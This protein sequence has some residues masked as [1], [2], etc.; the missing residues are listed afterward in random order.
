MMDPVAQALTCLVVVTLLWLATQLRKATPLQRH[1]YAGL[2]FICLAVV[3]CPTQ[4]QSLEVSF[5]GRIAG[6][7]LLG[8]LGLMNFVIPTAAGVRNH[9]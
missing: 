9:A 3:M 7:M 5:Q 1:F 6:A 8:F 2:V 4:A